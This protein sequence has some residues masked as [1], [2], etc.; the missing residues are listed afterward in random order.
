VDLGHGAVFGVTQSPDQGEDIETEL[1]MGQ[2]EVGLGLRAPGSVEA[3]TGRIGA[4]A[5][6]QRQ[7]GDGVES[8]DGAVVGVGGP[9]PLVASGAVAGH[10]GQGLD[11]RRPGAPLSTGH[12]SFLLA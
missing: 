1:M 11:A 8:G 7:S 10:R 12:E 3:V 2:G 5:D 6:V 9:Q 4:A